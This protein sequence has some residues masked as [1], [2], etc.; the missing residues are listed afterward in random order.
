MQGK[1]SIFKESVDLNVN[2]LCGNVTWLPFSLFSEV[3]FCIVLKD[4]ITIL[5]CLINWF[6]VGNVLSYNNNK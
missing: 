3:I 2:A 4:K 1:G 5:C 6:Y